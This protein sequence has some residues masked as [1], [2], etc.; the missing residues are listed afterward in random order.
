MR[1]QQQQEGDEP[2][3]LLPTP[4]S[5]PATSLPELL[6]SLASALPACSL[7]ALDGRQPAQQGAADATALVLQCGRA[8]AAVVHLQ[9]CGGLLPLRVAL[10][11]AAEAEAA[12]AGEGSASLWAPSQHVVFQQLTAQA[13]AALHH[14][15]QQ[16]ERASGAAEWASPL[17]LLLLWLA[18]CSDI[19][20]R[21]SGC[22]GSLLLAD[23]AAAGGG[24]LPPL[25]RPW[26]LGWRELW[27]A[28]LNPQLRQAEHLQAA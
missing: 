1:Q 9:S 3:A 13:A 5:Q 20:N 7:Q 25:H 4:V 12:L 24:L 19:F 16:Q 21:P 18:T 15:L 10:L 14:F 22:T 17:E 27:A 23:P 8:F 2:H 6:A 11:S 28:A 26:Q